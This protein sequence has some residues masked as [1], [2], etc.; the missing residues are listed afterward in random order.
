MFYSEEVID[1]VR[2]ANNIVDV[3]G[4]YVPLKKKGSTYFGPCP[5]H[6]EKTPSFSVTDNN[7]K[8]MYYCFGC[9]VG[10][11]V[12]SFVMKYENISYVEAIQMLAERAGIALPVPDY[13]KEKAERERKRQQVFDIN[14]LAGTYFFRLLRSERGST[15]LNYLKGR[16]L[17][18]STIVNFGLGYADKYKDDLYKY[19]KSLGYDDDIL[20][21]TG[22]FSIKE[23][24][25][26]DYFR[27]RVMFPIMD[28]RNKIVGFGGRVMGEGE[29]KYLNSPET[30]CFDKGRTLYGLNFAKKAQGRELV[31]VEGYMD[32][33]SLHQSGFTNAV[34]GLGTALTDGNV[35]TLRRYADSVI[36][37]YDSDSAG[38]NAT[39]RA[40]EKLKKAHLAVK[41]VNLRPY[42]DPDE[43][44]KAEG[45]DS[46]KDRLKSAMN[47]LIYEVYS[48]KEN[49]DLN[50]PDDKT[51]FYN[52]T[53]KKIAFFDDEIERNSYTAA[54]SREFF[55]DS[56]ALE[57][58][59]KRYALTRSAQGYFTVPAKT[60]KKKSE[61]AKNA[62]EECCRIVLSYVWSDADLYRMISGILKPK[63]FQAAPYTEMAEI[64]FSQRSAGRMNSAEVLDAFPEMEEREKAAQI[65]YYKPENMDEE[66]VRQTL[67][68]CVIRI[69]RNSLEK[70]LSEAADFGEMV[71]VKKE[72]ENLGSIKLFE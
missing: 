35:T 63:D 33:I 22:L 23:E 18:N 5:F 13:S 55:I 7:E 6:S 65:F 66:A 67:T 52:E 15:G 58:A 11:D 59:V 2:E 62:L 36:L 27:N 51:R 44:I 61:A 57:G 26:R 38:Q 21:E 41:V 69:K 47:S 19:I 68:D 71:A 64:I 3:I 53:A 10:G 37:S 17:S 24:G 25:S 28:V 29:P 72:M 16:G 9:H 34:A 4:T 60:V 14:K 40:I 48:L 12:I 42:K 31:L 30:V 8:H 45:P 56:Q 54:V 43:L 1:N 32:V 46:Y 50:N 39:L 49:Y 20:K 70:K